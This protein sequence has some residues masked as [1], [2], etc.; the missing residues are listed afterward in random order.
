MAIPNVVALWL[1]KARKSF[2]LSS[3]LYQEHQTPLA[4]NSEQSGQQH[5]NT[6]SKAA[7]ERACRGVEVLSRTF[8]RKEK[9]RHS[10]LVIVRKG[11]RT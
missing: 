1:D 10:T 4:T 2:A 11:I 5:R 3:P 9:V 8:D 6:A 7:A